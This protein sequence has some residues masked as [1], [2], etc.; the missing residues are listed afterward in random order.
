MK[1]KIIKAC[2][3][4]FIQTNEGNCIAPEGRTKALFL[5]NV[6]A[7]YPLVPDDFNEGL[8]ELNSK[9]EDGYLYRNDQLRITPVNNV[10][11]SEQS[12][13][14]IATA[15]PGDGFA[16][17]A[18]FNQ[19]AQTYRINGGLCLLKQLKRLNKKQ[20]RVFRIDDSGMIFGTER[21]QRSGNDFQGYLAYIMATDVLP[22]SNTEIFYIQLSIYYSA[23]YSN[24]RENAHAFALDSVPKGFVG[25]QLE[26][27]TAAGTAKVVEVCSGEDTTSVYGTEWE[28]S[29]FADKSGKAP[30]AVA[31]DT[32][33]GLL[34]FTPAGGE[35]RVLDASVLIKGDI[36]GIEGVNVYTKLVAGE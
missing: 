35:Y 10:S 24:E 15:D 6:N 18:G 29:M 16:I 3:D 12:G 17:P 8:Y 19:L 36:D 7:G 23:E 28:A 31:F 9:K 32:E 33:T 22:T 14:D 2:E 34:T 11:M 5:T 20:M 13:G 30:T 21:E 1:G 25:V 27:G 4:F 26:A